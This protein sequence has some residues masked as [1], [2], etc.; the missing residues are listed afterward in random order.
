MIHVGDIIYYYNDIDTLKN[1]RLIFFLQRVT[2]Q[3]SANFVFLTLAVVLELFAIATEADKQKLQIGVKKRVDA[4]K[5]KR[6]SRKGDVLAMHY[7]V[8][9]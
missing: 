1:N 2:M 9:V 6:R 4:D 5:C 8:S 7:S 3:L